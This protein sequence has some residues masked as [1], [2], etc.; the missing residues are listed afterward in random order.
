MSEHDDVWS[1]AEKRAGRIGTEEQTGFKK[2][3]KPRQ[4]QMIGFGGAIG[5]GLFL[6]S[7]GRLEQAGP[8]LLIDYAV[9]GIFAFLIL[10][11]LGE[12]VVHRPSSGSFVSYAREFYGE[13]MAFFSGWM[14]WVN[15]ATTSIVDVTAVAIYV[16][17]FGDVGML[18]WLQ[19]VP[20]WSIALIALVVVLGMNMISVKVFGELEFWAALIKVVALVAF[21][22]VGSLFL[23]FGMPDGSPRGPTLIFEN[24][25]M[26]PNGVMPALV[27]LQGVVFAYASIE[28][29][30][31]TAGETENPRKVIP[32]AI[33]TVVMRIALFYVGSVLLLVLLL[34]Y[35]AFHAGESPFVT[36]FRGVGFEAAAP[37]MELVV[38]TAALSSLNAG[39]YSTGRILHSM[40]KGGT[41]PAFAGRLSKAGVPYGGILLTSVV[42]LAGVVLNMV[43]PDQA[44]EIVLNLA[45]FGIISAWGTITLTN[46]RF[47]KLSK[48]GLYERPEYRMP[49][50][51]YTNWIT[52]VFLAAVVVLI[53]FDYPTGTF[54]M[55]SMVVVAAALVA[56]WFACRGRVRAIAEQRLGETGMFPVVANLP[57]EPGEA[58]LR[59]RVEG[60]VTH[61]DEAGGGGRH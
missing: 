48:L 20:Q 1:P 12:L 54:T 42:T 7:G 21:L 6:G 5:T 29:V 33:N 50:A 9:C 10:R 32:K 46:M 59:R 24:G 43:V 39:L 55:L 58:G 57:H 14:Y 22:V 41:A 19:G 26:F 47:V 40:A 61:D 17:W 3:L 2:G 35:T 37:I 49:G 36:L 31:T 27:I 53:G 44:F 23:I 45:A 11:A 16:K 51:P 34:P 60:R 38:L 15:W 25:G 18:P 13:K 56:G 4:V 8:A 30:G 28:L 52:L